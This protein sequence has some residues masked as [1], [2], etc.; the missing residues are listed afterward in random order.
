MNK[1]IS[2]RNLSLPLDMIDVICSYAFYTT[3]QFIAQQKEKY[4]L[5]FKQI[6]LIDRQTIVV[7]TTTNCIDYYHSRINLYYDKKTLRMNRNGEY[8]KYIHSEYKI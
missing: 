4:K 6:R 5:I 7:R 1:V 2:V 8:G 3:D